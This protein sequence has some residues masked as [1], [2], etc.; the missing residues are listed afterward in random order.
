MKSDSRPLPATFGLRDGEFY[1]TSLVQV[2]LLM[3][4]GFRAEQESRLPSGAWR[5]RVTATGGEGMSLEQAVS[6]IHDSRCLQGTDADKVEF[7]KT[8]TEIYQT[9]LREVKR[10]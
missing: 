3:A 6:G 10:D 2:A 4:L 8:A 1:T 5:F 9:L 7:F